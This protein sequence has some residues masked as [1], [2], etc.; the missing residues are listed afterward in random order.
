MSENDDD[1]LARL[2]AADPA[3]R[4]PLPSEHWIHDLTEATMTHTERHPRR[5]TWLVAAAAAVAVLVVGGG[6]TALNR[7]DE[8]AKPPTAQASDPASGPT[9]T[10][11]GAPPP[12]TAKCMV[13]NAQ[14]LKGAQVAFDG[15]VVAIDGD[16]VTLDVTT[17]YA[18]GPTDQVVV[19]APADDLRALLL[20][21]EFEQGKRFLVAAHDGQVMICGFSAAYDAGLAA[22]YAEAF[23]G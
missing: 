16:R 2:T 9:T 18:G 19:A 5:R 11:L 4:A 3:T 1:L 8:P 14:V 7:G 23:S 22:L 6:V 20:G 15:T 10:E 13:P 12:S 21:V 17:W